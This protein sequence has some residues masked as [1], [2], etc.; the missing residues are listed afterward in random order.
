M[1]IL[2]RMEGLKTPAPFTWLLR[3]KIRWL[4]VFTPLL[5]AYPVL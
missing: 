1:W 3:R 5:L 2:D 4:V